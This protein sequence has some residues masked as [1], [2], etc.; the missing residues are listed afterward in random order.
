MNKTV[1]L[2][3]TCQNFNTVPPL[4]GMTL[5]SVSMLLSQGFRHHRLHLSFNTGHYAVSKDI[6]P[7]CTVVLDTVKNIMVFDWWHPKYPHFDNKLPWNMGDEEAL[8]VLKKDFF[9]TK[10]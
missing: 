4:M 5:S 9:S 3:V 8:P 10:V 2:Q 1:S 7:E 6:L